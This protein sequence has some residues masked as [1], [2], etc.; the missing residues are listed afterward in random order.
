MGR[1]FRN[2]RYCVEHFMH[3]GGQDD[4]MV[5]KWFSTATDAAAYIGCS[6]SSFFNILEGKSPRYGSKFIAT[7]ETK[8]VFVRTEATEIYEPQAA[9]QHETI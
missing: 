6:R 8:P 2:Y 7:R 5:R 3:D 9:T 1:N 4:T